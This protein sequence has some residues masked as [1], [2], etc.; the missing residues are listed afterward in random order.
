V[1]QFAYQIGTQSHN[2]GILHELCISMDVLGSKST[3]S[4]FLIFL[5]NTAGLRFHIRLLDSHI[6]M[7]ICM[8]SA[9]QWMG[10]HGSEP[11]CI[12]SRHE[13]MSRRLSPH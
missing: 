13:P 6:R 2:S 10:E 12:Q 1:A 5:V 9:C 8:T 4:K 3:T 7:V 11:L